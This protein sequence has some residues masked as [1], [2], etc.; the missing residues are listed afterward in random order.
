M[1]SEWRST[2]GSTRKQ[3]AMLEGM[4]PDQYERSYLRHR[5]WGGANEAHAYAKAVGANLRIV[6][7]SGAVMAEW[8]YCSED[9]GM[10][11]WVYDSQHYWLLSGGSLKSRW[12]K[13]GTGSYSLVSSSRGGG[14]RGTH[15]KAARGRS[16]LRLL[17]YARSKAL[18]RPPLPMYVGPDGPPEREAP[19]CPDDADPRPPLERRKRQRTPLPRRRRQDRETGH[20]SENVIQLGALPPFDIAMAAAK[21]KPMPLVKRMAR[22]T[23]TTPAKAP[24]PVQTPFEIAMAAA[25]AKPTPLSMRMSRPTPITP[26][27]AHA[28]EQPPRQV[29]WKEPIQI[30]VGGTFQGPMTWACDT[31]LER[32]YQD[33]LEY[34]EGLTV[35]IKGDLYCLL[36]RRWLHGNHLLAVKH[37]QKLQGYVDLDPMERLER[38][39]DLREAARLATGEEVYQLDLNQARGGMQSGGE[40]SSGDLRPTQGL[41]SSV[42]EPVQ[43]D[44]VDSGSGCSS[45]GG[46]GENACVQEAPVSEVAS[47]DIHKVCVQATRFDIS[48]TVCKHTEVIEILASLAIIMKVPTWK[49]ALISKG[50][51]LLRSIGVLEA[52]QHGW[53]WVATT[54][55]IS[56]GPAK[57]KLRCTPT[58][59]LPP[60]DLLCE[61]C[62]QD[63]EEEWSSWDDEI[64]ARELMENSGERDPREESADMQNHDHSIECVWV[65]NHRESR[66]EQ[67]IRGTQ[68]KEYLD[69]YARWKRVRRDALSMFRESD[70]EHQL[71]EGDNCLVHKGKSRRGGL[72]VTIEKLDGTVAMYEVDPTLTV[73]HLRIYEHVQDTVLLH[74]GAVADDGIMLVLL[75]THVFVE[76]YPTSDRSYLRTWKDTSVSKIIS[77][78]EL[79]EWFG[80]CDLEEE[81]RSHRL[82]RMVQRWKRCIAFYHASL[83]WDRRRG[84]TGKRRDHKSPWEST[85]TVKGTKLL[86]DYKD[87][88][89]ELKQVC[90]ESIGP[91][92]KGVGLCLIAT[93][94]KLKEQTLKGPLALVFPGHCEKVLVR[95]GAPQD[96]VKQHE[97]ILADPDLDEPFPRKVTTLC[98]VD[99]MNLEMGS[100]IKKI[101]F[102]PVMT[103]ELLIELDTRWSPDQVKLA[104]QKD[105]P[106]TVKMM[107]AKL[108][109]EVMTDVVFFGLRTPQPDSVIPM[110][111]ARTRL[112][113][114]FAEKALCGSGTDGLFVRP[115]DTSVFGGKDTY[116]IV[117]TVKH[118]VASTVELNQLLT[119]AG[120]I[121]GHRGVA[122]SLTGLGLRVPWSRI[123]EARKLLK[124]D[125]PMWTDQNIGIKDRLTYVVKN[126]PSGTSASDI[127]KAMNQLEWPVLPQAPA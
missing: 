47:P 55:P 35:V 80:E 38:R 46:E 69:H 39:R 36:C 99:G 68:V 34:R 4:T 78:A 59:H 74:K 29:M 56:S 20:P 90:A 58:I 31:A 27:K 5:G 110:W 113:L 97:V 14:K 44:G 62:K 76:A 42:P 28:P 66:Q 15:P 104:A 86:T 101:E 3:V 121:L 109:M 41:V 19:P 82:L 23:P 96:N 43:M 125:H 9:K 114:P 112:T 11:V 88:G 85:A 91:E 111:T 22:S 2:V 70:G 17:K 115:S 25:K 108:V 103:A 122:R 95:L 105:W 83:Y 32:N 89:V 87:H 102:Q 50:H 106:A 26:S 18:S 30:V 60:Q 21:A 63:V 64:L 107:L 24:V 117:W 51:Q 92:T 98:A 84:G 7:A 119:C 81:C 94:V 61:S 49:V 13:A 100:S 75:S 123:A 33:K 48:F 124:P 126:C 40:S 120:K 53:H 52:A 73:H 16:M 57:F 65:S 118:E 116:A 93:W 1:I 67:V 54:L 71:R 79:C 77:L 37:I 8:R 127:V 6:L 45:A 72:K 12:A 10:D